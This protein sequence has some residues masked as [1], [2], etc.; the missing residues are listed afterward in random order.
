MSNITLQAIT[1]LLQPRIKPLHITPYKNIL[2]IHN[3]TKLHAWIHHP[4]G[5]PTITLCTLCT[6]P[7][8]TRKIHKYNLADP[9]L[10]QQLTNHITTV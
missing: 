10:L 2:D 9:N 6:Y 3:S 1:K 4:P 8:S 7:N 5:S